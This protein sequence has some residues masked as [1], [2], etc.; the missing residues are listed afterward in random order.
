MNTLNMST[1]KQSALLR[2]DNYWQGNWQN[3][4]QRFA[5]TNPATGELLAE[6]A[7]ATP[8]QAQ[9][10]V[11]AAAEAFGSWSALPA[12]ERSALLLRWHQLLLAHQDELALL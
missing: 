7:D 6:V 11:S 9:Q 8:A 10:A 3:A 1:L 12:A 2:N 5:V 4:T